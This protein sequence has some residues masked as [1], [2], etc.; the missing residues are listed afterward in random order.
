MKRR[1]FI[2]LTAGIL[3]PRRPSDFTDLGVATPV[4][5]PRGTVATRDGEGR[6]VVLVLLLDHRGGYALLMIDVETGRSAQFPM[7]F[8]PGGDAPY[9]SILSSRNRFYMHFNGHFCE[10]DPSARR[11][12]FE[13]S[14]TPGAA[15]SM[16]EADEGT[17]WSATYPSCGLVSFHPETGK[18]RDFGSVHTENWAQYPRSLADDDGGWLYCGIGNAAAQ[19]VA[20]DPTTALARTILPESERPRGAAVVYRDINGRVYGHPPGGEDNGWYELHRGQ[21]S[22]LGTLTQRRPKAVI[23]SDQNLFYRQ[24][25]G[26]RRLERCDLEKRELTVSDPA[27]KKKIQVRFEY[28]T[29]GALIMALAA[30][31]DG[32]LCGGTAFPM[33]FFRYDSE[34][35]GIDNR[36]AYAQFNTVASQG[37]RVFFGGYPRGF[38]LE[39]DPKR[40]WVETVQGNANSNP[41]FLTDCEPVI[42]RPHKLLALPDGRT[43][44][45]AGTPGY[46]YTGGGLLFWD[47][48][49][50]TRVLLEAAAILAG[51]STMSMAAARAKILGGTTVN[52]GTGGEKL[53]SEAELYLLDVGSRKVEWHSAPLPGVQAY[54]D[55]CVG[56]NGLV[57]G[58]ADQR[59]FFVFSL[60][61]RR[62][63]HHRDT[64]A[65]FGVAVAQQ[66]PR[67]IVPDGGGRFFIL[68][69]TGI[70]ELDPA[71]YTIR[72]LARPPS[73]VSAGGDCLSGRFYFASS[74]HIWSYRIPK[75]GERSSR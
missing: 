72:M 23:T 8:K 71:R 66:G 19:I 16:T 13:H 12:T 50:R 57:F 68:F 4:S 40:P 39:W 45:L 26:G 70:A 51:H 49:S 59:R 46:G 54:T 41:L 62:I 6:P 27:T 73:P 35:G 1:S 43:L 53:A 31:P 17:I 7:P 47:R 37:D 9:A 58:I 75:R 25:P 10:F 36:A 24:F 65:E 5:Y 21:A 11:F 34:S 56:P 74:S 42:G 20:F 18:L 52:P 32:T 60:A 55:L 22:R 64:A 2:G 28:A 29:E 30:A 44:V 63:V 14:T 38:L 69:A 15:M 3:L 61:E 67:V 33:R 48:Q